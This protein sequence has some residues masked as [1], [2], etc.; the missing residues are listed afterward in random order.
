MPDKQVSRVDIEK[1]GID[2]RETAEK[3]MANLA[4]GPLPKQP[5]GRNVSWY[6]SLYGSTGPAT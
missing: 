5:A 3:I 6:E 1:A 2:M 4:P